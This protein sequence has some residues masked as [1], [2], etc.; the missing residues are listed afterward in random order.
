[1]TQIFR[2][3]I[4]VFVV[5]F[6][7]T[8]SVH[9]AS[10]NIVLILADDLGFT[11]TQPYGSEIET[12]NISRLANEGVI[13]T[14]Y[15]TGASCAPSRAM[16]MTGVNSHR[17]GVPEV[18]E[19]LTPEMTEHENY[20]GTLSHN[21]VTVAT[22]LKDAGYHTY[23]TGKWHLGKTPDLLPS[24]RGFERTVTMLDTGA[25]NWEKK[26]YS[27]MNVKANWYADGKEIDLPEDF[28]SSEFYIDKAIEFIE[29]NRSDGKPFFSYIPFQAVHIPV[30][31]PKEFSD[32]YQG[33]YEKGWQDLRASRLEAVKKLGLLPESTRLADMPSMKEWI[34]LSKEQKQYEARKMEV[35]AGMV[36]AMD[37]H[38]GRLIQ[39]LKETGEYDNTVFIFTSDNGAQV[40]NLFSRTP[41][42]GLFFRLWMK[43]KG[44]NM[45]YETLGE[46]GSHI[47]MGESFASAVA[48]PLAYYKFHTG[49]GG[50]RVPMII[51]GSNITQKGTVSNALTFVT[52]IT[53]TILE[54]AGV[55]QPQNTYKD[56]EVEPIIGKSLLPI[57]IGEADRV[58]EADE[59][60]GHELSSSAALFKGDYKLVKNLSFHG[61]RIWHLYN[62]V[63]DPGESTDLKE[64]M[65]E[66]F[67]EMMAGYLDYEKKNGV[68]PVPD[69]FNA[70]TAMSQYS[71]RKQLRA[72]AW[73]FVMAIILI[74]TLLYWRIRSHRKLKAEDPEF[75]LVTLK[76]KIIDKTIRPYL[77]IAG[78]MTM[79]PLMMLYAPE[80]GLMRLFQLKLVAEYTLAVQHWGLMI[81]LVG[82]LMV[83]SAFRT[84]LIF[85]VMLYATLSKGGMVV[86]TVANANYNWVE[87][88]LQPALFDFIC[89][90]Y[91][92]FYFQVQRRKKKREQ[93]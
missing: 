46:R 25:D 34:S 4:V 45:D 18:P 63:T 8:G 77:V 53:P 12:P 38:I 79:G 90:V 35:Y 84:G 36:D 3:I 82:L 81:F 59:A 6:S 1:M 68:Q 87:G 86:L 47:F 17:A 73:G 14:N 30:Q 74:L 76:E 58:Y 9:A 54:I 51:A 52:D 66:R 41:M 78:L 49:E 71:M 33:R 39:Y 57:A 92:I 27:P 19:A 85:P 75:Q 26:P 42:E 64:Q 16:L 88:F 70:M 67:N 32:K 60:V 91:A 72:N 89:V 28:Y 2:S 10:P 83:V 56:R 24:Q 37:H 7:W 29:S 69:D 62:I 22:L 21:V 40:S 11:D 31:A 65:P 5:I 61:D 44:Y 48:S 20:D 50:L 23:L 55:D 43:Q 93:A 80:A 15:H 13:F